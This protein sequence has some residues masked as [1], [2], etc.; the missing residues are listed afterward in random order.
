MKLWSIQ[1]LRFV[2]ALL[3]LHVHAI[4]WLM[5]F[6]GDPGIFGRPATLFGRCGVDLF[7]VISGLIIAR[8]ATGLTASDF[9]AKRARRIL[10]MYILAS[11]PWVLA[12]LAIGSFSWRQMISTGLLWPATDVITPPSLPVGWTLCFEMLFYLCF[13]MVIWRKWLMWPILGTFL[14]ALLFGRG[15]VASFVG[16]PIILEFLFGVALAYAPPARWAIAGIPIGIAILVL[17]AAWNWPPFGGV[18]DFLAGADGWLR[19][20][21][22]GVPAALIVWGALQIDTKKSILT[23]LGDASYSIYLFHTPLLTAIVWIMAKFSRAPSDLIMSVAIGLTILVCWRIHELFEKPLLAFLG[24]PLLSA[25]E[26]Y[27]T[28]G[29]RICAS[30]VQDFQSHVKQ[31]A[32]EN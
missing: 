15:A 2:A 30:Q 9:I 21:T 27:T 10:P 8:T 19:V 28:P 32:A 1:V 7:F 23:K 31:A 17:G 3:V 11:L 24:R 14:F 29:E 25:R 26:T 20:A 5:D 13:A 12:G 16:N 22:L 18:K 4:E 6:R